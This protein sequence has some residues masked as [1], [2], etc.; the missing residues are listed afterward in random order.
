MNRSAPP[1]RPALRASPLPWTLLSTALLCLS[2]C[3]HDEQPV[4]RPLPPLQGDTAAAQPRV[5]GDI[6]TTDQLSAPRISYGRNR[7]PAVRTAVRPEGDGTVSLDFADTDIRDAVAQILGSMLHVTYTIDPAVKGMVTLHTAAPLAQSQLLSTLQLLLAQVGATLYQ[8]N[9]VYRVVAAA[10]APSP[11]ASGSAAAAGA[12]P[13]LASGDAFAGS[14]MVPLNYAGAEDLAKALQPFVQSGARIT[15]AQGAN[16]LLVSGDPQVRE[17]LVSLIRAFDIDAL[18]GQSYALL[19]VDSG[20]A[21]DIA[22]SLQEALKGRGGALS[23][24]VRVVPMARVDAVL[25]IANAP[26]YVDDARRLFG[27]IEQ[28]RR[29]TVRSWHVYYLQNSHANDA[30]YVLQQAFTPGDVTA[31]PTP[32]L[33]AA[34][35]GQQGIGGS[36]GGLGSGSGLGSTGG[37]GSSGGL[38]STGGL[39]SSGGIGSSGGLGSAGGLGTGQGGT[40]TTGSAGGQTAGAN[41]LLGGLGGGEGGGAEA[42]TMRIIPNPQNNALLV[43]ATAQENDTIGQMLRKIDIL[44]LQVRIDAVIAEVTLNDQLQYGTQFFFKSGGVN[45]ILSNASQSITGTLASAAFSTTLPGF[46]IG[47]AS[48]NGGAPFAINALQ[49]VTTV[50]I[51]SSPELLVLDNQTASLQVGQL[52]PIQ[53][54]SQTSALGS[55]SVFNQDTYQPT[56]VI[57]QVTPRVNDGGLVTLDVSQQVSSVASPATNTITNPTFNNQSVISRIVV[58]D[59]QTA[60]LA[61]LITDQSSRLNQGIPWLKDIPVLGLLAG[62]QANL[63]QRTELLILI[64]PHVEHDQRDARA[65]TEDLRDSLV[66][67]AA[68]PE[69]LGPQRQTGSSDPQRRLR[70]KVGLGP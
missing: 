32:A 50:H 52:V 8:T 41:P 44:P 3:N 22:T 16:A 19:P 10:N 12:P 27:L 68:V 18:A 39:G 24:V 23:Q 43:Y 21:K 46:V 1:P 47:S 54:G 17:T 66:N 45:G 60:G 29:T 14:A 67:A 62:N 70:D 35:G 26:Q 58:Q 53:T 31:Q 56:G 15:A 38:G 20:S 13:V 7:E 42:R 48:G 69:E 59:G 28:V 30:A 9:G 36:S 55:G 51:L 6:G 57:L 25:V 61:G 2:G 63:R 34:Q 33:Q 40:S 37:L 11:G 49:A 65:L 5:N 4:I 64:T